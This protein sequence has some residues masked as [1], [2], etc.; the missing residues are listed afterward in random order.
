MKHFLGINDAEFIRGDAPMTKSEIRI[1]TLAKAHIEASSIVFD[2]GAGTGS[3]SIE[4]A[5]LASHGQVYAIEK[6]KK[7]LE[8][9][10]KNV[11]K[12]IVPNLIICAQEAPEG[13][14]SLPQADVI[15]VGGNGGRLREIIRWSEKH[16][17][18]GGRIL[19]NCITIQTV[20]TILSYFHE[21]K[22]SDYNCE[23]VQ[24]QVNRLHKVGSLDMFQANNPVFIITCIKNTNQE[25]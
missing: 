13:L 17:R 8:L 18:Q 23:A 12:F 25:G 1:L 22:E 10:Q 21:E 20:N 9:L 15:I 7:A 4:A 16:L 11:N 2:V 14:D 24:V 6:N 5:K 3:I 19:F